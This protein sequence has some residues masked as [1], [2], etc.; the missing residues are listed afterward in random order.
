MEYLADRIQHRVK[1]GAILGLA[2]RCQVS[3]GAIVLVPPF[4]G[5]LQVHLLPFRMPILREPA[6]ILRKHLSKATD[7]VALLGAEVE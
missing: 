6:D 5:V 1:L 4:Q 3:P 2:R 7:I